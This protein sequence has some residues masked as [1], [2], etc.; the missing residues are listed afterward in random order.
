M[1]A[2]I[3]I[4]V[5]AGAQDQVRYWRS[6]A[7]GRES[8]V[9]ATRCVFLALY[10]FRRGN[11]QTRNTTVL[12]LMFERDVVPESNVPVG[13]AYKDVGVLGYRT[14]ALSVDVPSTTQ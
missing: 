9:C 5:C 14:A 1:V 12:N 10:G 8:C 4:P 13:V 2:A 6:S 7:A 11:G 3:L